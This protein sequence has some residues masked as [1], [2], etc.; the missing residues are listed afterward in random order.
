MIINLEYFIM[1]IAALITLVLLLF[2]VDWRYFRDWIVVFFFKC[3]LDFIWGGAVENLKLLEYPV[4]LLPKYFET[5]LLFEVWVFPVL[6]I[7]YNQT[8]R[9]RGLVGIIWYALLFSAL[10]TAIEYPLE[11]YTNLIKYKSWSWFTTLYTLTLTF[12][13]S[14]AFIGFYRWGCDYFSQKR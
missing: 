11:L 4:R 1:V 3:T 12:L 14:R 7:L 2:M 13:A 8:T 6:C 9:T 5:S 10:I